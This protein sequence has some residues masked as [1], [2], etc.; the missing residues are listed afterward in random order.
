MQIWQAPPEYGPEPDLSMERRVMER[1][2][3]YYKDYMITPRRIFDPKN[4][5][6][7]ARY[8]DKDDSLLPGRITVNPTDP[9]YADELQLQRTYAMNMRTPGGR[10][11]VAYYSG[12][13]LSGEEAGNYI[14][15]VSSDDDA[16]SFG[17]R[18]LIVPPKE[19]N[20]RVFDPNMWIDDLGR[21]WIFWHQSYLSYDG[22]IGVWVTRC[23]NPDEDQ[24]KFTAP[25]R[26]ANGILAT[27]PVIL[28]SGEWM[29]PIY[30]WDAR[31]AQEWNCVDYWLNW[32]PDE[33]GSNVYRTADRGE[34][35]ERIANI[36]FAFSNFDEPSMVERSD[37]SIWML[38]RGL[39]CVGETFSYD[40][41]HTWTIPHQNRRLNLPDTH[42]YLGKLKN[43]DLLLLANYKADM[44][45]Y[46]CGRNRLTALISRD[47][48][49]TWEGFLSIDEREG[50]EQPDFTEGDNGFIYISYGRAP[51]I[52]GET[53]MAVVTEEDILAGR[54]VNPASQLKILVGKA[55][56]IEKR[57]DYEEWCE[58]ARKNKVE[59]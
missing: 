20:T 40:G 31:V 16:H 7:A 24:M 17:N 50:S 21:M 22:R 36:H 12:V 3:N 25:R 26:I 56:G 11:F 2:F 34:T 1:E 13:A 51:Q 52:A 38:I 19:H 46:Y 47:D 27:K 15:I 4:D 6:E 39:N 42:F 49:A 58:F 35:F 59:M 5:P 37:G 29:L 53:L 10:I 54:L 18:I 41:G 55:R 32:L 57:A 23:D 30:L 48:G 28:R 9:R 44:F 43:G 45:T 14:M 33:Q 8:A